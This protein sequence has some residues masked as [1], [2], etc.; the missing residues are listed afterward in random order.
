MKIK[1][2]GISASPRKGNSSFLLETAIS[3][4]LDE[5]PTSEYEIYAFT[6]KKISPCIHCNVCKKEGE[7]AIK[8]D[9]QELRDKWMSAD[10]IIYSVPV[11]HMGIPGQ[12][13]CFIDRLGQSTIQKY[14]KEGLYGK[15]KF[16]KVI[17]IIAQGAHLCSGQEHAATEL[18]NHAILMGSLPVAGDVWES[19]VG[20]LGWTE[21]KIEK[22]S[23]ESLKKEES[24]DANVMMKACKTLGKRCIQMATVVRSGL[25]AR[26]EELSKD[27]AFGFIYR[28]IAS[29][30][31]T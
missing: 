17:G 28:K 11:Y 15:P 13:K 25:N 10:V 4:A 1:I 29:G 31:D 5:L 30:G 22:N 18:I 14:K 27:A 24:F 12:L 23:F 19:Y 9:F 8:D 6:G 16:L 3:S 20:A 7:C 26:K 21:N 2:L